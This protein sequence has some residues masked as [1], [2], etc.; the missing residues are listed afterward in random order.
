MKKILN[1]ILILLI[2]MTLY[3]INQKNSPNGR[4]IIE[5]R[6]SV[7]NTNQAVDDLAE[8]YNLNILYIFTSINSFAVENTSFFK[9]LLLATDKKIKYF[10]PDFEISIAQGSI[11]EPQ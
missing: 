2:A 1:I 7:V 9:M 5:L 4:Y 11:Y 8:K 10:E 6:D 3:F